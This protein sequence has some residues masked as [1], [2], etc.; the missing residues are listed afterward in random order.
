MLGI[1]A[2]MTLRGLIALARVQLESATNIDLKA[3]GLQNQN[4]GVMAGAVFG[5]KDGAARAAAAVAVAAALL[6]F[7]F[8][9]A[10]FRRSATN[11]AA[12]LVIGLAVVAGW[13]VTGVIA[14][15][16]FN[17]VPLASI[18]FVSPVGESLQYLMTFTG[19]TINFGIAVVGGVIAGS[20]LMAMATGT[21]QIE[22][23]AD[24]NDLVRH[25]SGAT[26]MG[27]GG[28]LALGCT[29]GQGITGMS[30]LA[31][32]SMIAWLSIIGWRLSWGEISR[33]GLAR[34]RDPCGVRPRLRKRHAVRLP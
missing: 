21:F 11:I 19:S 7:C 17:P 31:L 13:V 22:S 18:T 20:F 23:F 32:G 9:D 5:L 14:A 25:L 30:T 16:E 24:R 4:I 6:V 15:D 28:V 8:K 34:R 26:L 27:A 10:A 2:Y 1:V 29:I 3:R 12:G 33:G